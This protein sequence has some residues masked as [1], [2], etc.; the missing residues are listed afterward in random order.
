MAARDAAEGEIAADVRAEWRP[1]LCRRLAAAPVEAAELRVSP[2]ELAPDADAY[3]L[4][5]GVTNNSSVS[6]GV[7]HGTVIQA[8]NIGRSHHREGPGE[9]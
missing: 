1:R 4:H 6:G 9:R 8:R 7:F 3:A 2:P 5:R